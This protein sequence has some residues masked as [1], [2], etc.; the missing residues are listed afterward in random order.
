M[1]H[2]NHHRSRG[3]ARTQGRSGR[4]DARRSWPVPG[5]S[6][7]AIKPPALSSLEAGT[8]VLAHVPFA[9]RD[10]WKTRPAVILTVGDRA[11][12]VQPV[13]SSWTRGAFGCLELA[14]WS[15]AG[16]SR[17]CALMRRSVNLDR[18][19]DLISVI[20]HLSARDWESVVAWLPPETLT[21][22][23]AVQSASRDAATSTV[24]EGLLDPT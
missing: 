18:R 10:D 15:D 6:H 4:A 23:T 17:P 20:G 8:V 24:Y 1:S 2:G 7:K 3:G 19:L 5:T 11:V 12:V 13:T 9:E 21:T 16:L 14:D 22:I